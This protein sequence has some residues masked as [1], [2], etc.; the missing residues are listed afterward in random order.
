VAFESIE[1]VPQPERFVRELARLTRA[2]DGIFLCSTPNR[3]FTGCGDGAKS[4]SNPYHV[5]EFSPTE[6]LALLEGRFESVRLLGQHKTA[7][8][9]GVEELFGL[10]WHQPFIRLGRFL[11]HLWGRKIS[12][13][14]LVP[15]PADYV[16]TEMNA[17]LA[18]TL[19]AVCRNPKLE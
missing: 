2:A 18:W 14:I 15:T 13:P 6:L 5:K 12:R 10:F 11:Q 3:V 16:I 7:A 4:P 17:D 1:H 9:Q 8:L 19:L